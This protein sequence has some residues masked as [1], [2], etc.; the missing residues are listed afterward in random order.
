M[1]EGARGDPPGSWQPPGPDAAEAPRL[2]L[3]D[4]GLLFEARARR[5]RALAQGHPAEAWLQ[6]LARV[7]DGQRAAVRAVPVK[8]A[9]AGG[10]GPPLARERVP[11]DETW[12]RMLA[13]V[14]ES[15]RAAG[16][17]PET[18][19]ALRRLAQASPGE[20]ED[21]AA[22]ALA[23]EVAE[24]RLAAAPFVAAALQAWFT[25]LAAGLDPSKVAEGDRECPVCGTPPVASIVTTAERRR[26]LVCALC[27][28]EWHFPRIHCAACRA[29]SAISYLH[30]ESDPTAQAE[31]CGVCKSYLKQFDLQKRTGA[32]PIADDAATIGLDMLMADQE[33][34][35]AGVNPFVAGGS[36][37]GG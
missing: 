28:A 17:P 13:T 1:S 20:L 22:K 7:A 3:P 18:A 19:E 31:A 26:F 37:A 23:G 30:V 5:F 12:R 16:L 25:A 24:D 11:R 36:A 21:L 27:S 35:P 14:L 29:N 6:L 15:A 34:K 9:R 4:P 33:W 2:R 32:D 10:E 8:P